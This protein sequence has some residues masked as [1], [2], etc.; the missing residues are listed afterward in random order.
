MTATPDTIDRARERVRV[1][2]EMELQL[3]DRR[4]ALADRLPGLLGA[5]GKRALEALARTGQPTGAADEIIATE[6]EVRA[7]DAAIVEA[8]SQRLAAIEAVYKFEALTYHD[9]A[10]ALMAEVEQLEPKIAEALAALQEIA[11][12]PYTPAVVGP[13]PDGTYSWSSYLTT[14]AQLRQRADELKVQEHNCI[15]RR[16][17]QA[18]TISAPSAVGI[19]EQ[20]RA[21]DP[22]TVGPTLA[23]A[24]AWAGPAEQPLRARLERA[25]DP[26]N[27]LHGAELALTMAWQDARITGQSSARLIPRPPARRDWEGIRQ[28][29][30]GEPERG[31]T[32]PTLHLGGTVPMPSE[33]PFIAAPSRS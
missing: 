6:A 2:Y 31:P 3:A 27:E 23:D 21:L 16:P 19:L 33:D 1:L 14:A 11:G 15:N 7:M 4:L 10:A 22:M 5:A 30:P 9:Q 12:C 25:S 13:L 32:T 17:V 26:F 24:A 18:G 8:R 20:I 29:P 28:V